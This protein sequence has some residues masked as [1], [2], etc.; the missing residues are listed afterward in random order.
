MVDRN[1]FSSKV[2]IRSCLGIFIF[3]ISACT[4]AGP[5]NGSSQIFPPCELSQTQ[6]NP[7]LSHQQLYQQSQ[8]RSGAVLIYDDF[9]TARITFDDAK[10]RAFSQLWRGTKHWSDYVDVAIDD[11]QMVRITVTYIDPALVEYIILNNVLFLNATNDDTNT[12][13]SKLSTVLNKLAERDEMLFMLIITAPT[14]SEQAYNTNVLNV[15]IPLRNIA[16]IN[17]SDLR[18]YPTHD[19]HIL[20]ETIQI[21][22]GPVA[23]VVGYPISVKVQENCTWVI[24]EHTNA[25]TLDVPDV[26]LGETKLGSQFW[27]VPYRSLIEVDIGNA[28]IV[29]DPYID[30]GR[31]QRLEEPPRPNWV[32]NAIKDMTDQTYWE[33][34][35][36]FI[37]DYFMKNNDF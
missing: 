12:F 30:L 16:L 35:G 23:G 36:R 8:T 18:V 13:I 37:W 27:H 33:D 10:R 32:P 31:I 11:T 26:T 14:Y 21:T 29:Y 2:F 17:G 3:I 9:K 20:D 19:D 7:Y 4:A 6:T 22:H 28:N 15:K 5:V 24:D 34:M 25:L 1:S